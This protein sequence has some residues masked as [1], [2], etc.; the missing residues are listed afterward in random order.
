M[1]NS[2]VEHG[3]LVVEGRLLFDG[4]IPLASVSKHRHFHSLNTTSVYLAVLLT[5]WP[6]AVVEIGTNTLHPIIA[7]WLNYSQR[8]R[9]S[10]EWTGL[11][12]GEVKSAL[13]GPTNWVPSCI[14]TYLFCIIKHEIEMLLWIIVLTWLVIDKSQHFASIFYRNNPVNPKH[15]QGSY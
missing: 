2:T 7:T 12:G 8:N 14:R 3:R 13:S 11:P 1:C 10:I 6:E 15:K 9:V 5:T 4:L